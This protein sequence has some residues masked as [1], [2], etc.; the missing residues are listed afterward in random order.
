MIELPKLDPRD[1][2]EVV[3]DVIDDLPAEISDRNAASPEVKLIEAIGAFYAVILFMLN[4]VP[5]RLLLQMFNLL[6]L[7]PEPAKSATV[8]IQFTRSSTVTEYT[9]PGSTIVKT[10]TDLDGVKFQTTAA[11]FFPIGTAVL[12][13]N[14][15]A[16]EP[17]AQGNVGANTLKLL[18]EPLSAIDSV[19][20]LLSATGGQDE[21]PIASVEQRAPLAIRAGERAITNEDFKVHAEA[22]GGVQRAIAFL[23]AG[24]AAVYILDNTLNE[25][26][27]AGLS[28]ETKTELEDRTLPSIAV[29]VNFAPVRM[30]RIT[31]VELELIS[32][33]PSSGTLSD[34]VHQRLTE[35]I[36]ADNIYADDGYT[37]DHPGWPWGKTLYANQ[38]V[39]ALGNLKGVVRVGDIS[40]EYSDNHGGSWTSAGLTLDS[41]VAFSS[42]TGLLQYDVDTTPLIVEL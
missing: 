34:N 38:V 28:T 25:T 36:S 16:L 1:E 15:E 37:I 29:A 9:V 4:Q 21:E 41:I 18:D 31:D 19:T 13:V 40:A 26:P 11:L 42:N 33:A 12:E 3:A 24:A 20:N 17:G 8:L 7:T 35:L 30:V 27:E 22:I 39:A 6:G 5:R 10:S 23:T 32:D 2:S 14:A